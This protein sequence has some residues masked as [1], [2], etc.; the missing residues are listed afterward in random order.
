MRE[1]PNLELH[2]DRSMKRSDEQYT[3]WLQCGGVEPNDILMRENRENALREARDSYI[4][5]ATEARDR[6]IKTIL[7]DYS[8]R[9]N[10]IKRSSHR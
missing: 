8:R 1:L 2:L 6:N 4:Q 10:E 5:E 9:V 7:R 3:T